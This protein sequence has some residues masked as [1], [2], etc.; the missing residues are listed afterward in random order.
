MTDT[1][2]VRHDQ[3]S[4]AYTLAQTLPDGHPF[5]AKY[6]STSTL[7]RLLLGLAGQLEAFED[8]L[9]TATDEYDFRV[10]TA[11][12]NEWETAVGIPDGCLN[13]DGDI[14][15][16][17]RDIAAKVF[18]RGTQT[19]QDLI[20]LAAV[21]GF[22]ATVVGGIDTAPLLFPWQT[23]PYT[24]AQQKEARFT[25]IVTLD[26][27]TPSVFPFTFPIIFGGT[28]ALNVKCFMR[29]I[30]PANV[31]LIFHEE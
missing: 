6:L 16:R 22:T 1:R 19:A 20:D 15:T 14:E 28:E 29:H 10:T 12:I 5:A 25:I 17:R 27:T 31:Q 21:F 26:V 3:A 18:S 2:I 11:W 30:V 8:K 23:P 7:Y 4:H 9:V 13:A 24:A